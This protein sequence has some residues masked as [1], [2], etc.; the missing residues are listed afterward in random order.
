MLVRW[1]AFGGS[2]YVGADSW[3][4]TKAYKGFAPEAGGA[5][6]HGEE[7]AVEGEEAQ[8]LSEVSVLLVEPN[9]G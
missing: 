1:K 3:T 7:V 4:H 5:C 2:R 6:L 8:A 9:A